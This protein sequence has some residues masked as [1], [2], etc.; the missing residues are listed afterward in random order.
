MLTLK[1]SKRKSV[2]TIM[3]AIAVFFTAIAGTV[4]ID[5]V[6][7]ATEKVTIDGS[8][9]QV[10]YDSHVTTLRSVTHIN[11]EPVDTSDVS[12][13]KISRAYCVQPQ[14][15]GPADG[16]YKIT[17]I[18]DDTTGLKSN[19]RKVAY[20]SP[21]ASGYAKYKAKLQKRIPDSFP[22]GTNGSYAAAHVI[23]SYIY[24]KIGSNDSAWDMGLSTKSKEQILDLYKYILD[25]PDPPESFEV[26]Y[27]KVSG[28][29][30]VLGALYMEELQPLRYRP[31][32][33]M[34]G[35]VSANL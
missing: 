34:N 15:P 19:L 27:I 35:A 30:D 4:P 9:K 10:H 7:A 16:E 11:G 22:G 17:V 31:D 3:L 25:L 24:N 21:G 13:V 18:T 6:N 1:R 12:G 14:L 20:Y 2:M 5:T 32:S 23:L 33:C 28:K 26:F 8:D 29:Q